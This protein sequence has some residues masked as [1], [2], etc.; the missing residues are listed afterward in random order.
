MAEPPPPLRPMTG[1]S[2]HADGASGCFSTGDGAW[3]PEGLGTSQ[4]RRWPIPNLEIYKQN[5]PT[6]VHSCRRDIP[7]AGLSLFFIL[8]TAKLG[9]EVFLLFSFFFF[10]IMT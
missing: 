10:L 9:L 7:F 8:S 5:S 6:M 4:G 1:C 2:A 3:I